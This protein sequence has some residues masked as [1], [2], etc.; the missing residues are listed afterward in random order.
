MKIPPLV[1]M[2]SDFGTRDGYVGAMKGAVLI[3]CPD[4]RIIDVSHQV[5]PHDVEAGAFLLSRAVRDL[6]PSTVHL[7]VVDPGVGSERRAVAARTADGIW[8]VGPDNGLV[9]GA[10]ADFGLCI[11]LDPSRVVPGAAP[12]ATFHGRDLFGPAAGRLA[13]GDDPAALGDVTTEMPRRLDR[14]VAVTGDV[15]TGDVVWI[16]R[17]GNA[18]TAITPEDLAALGESVRVEIDDSTVDGLSR[19]YADVERGRT[20]AYWGSHRTLEV[21]QR[22]AHFA[23]RHGIGRGSRVRVRRAGS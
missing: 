2:L 11:E 21:G 6:P 3:H 7:A 9:G 8:V 10:D 5:P 1:G 17:F 20:L 22:D 18:V 15:V 16:D 4:A 13:H 14:P 23:D 19:T 12:S